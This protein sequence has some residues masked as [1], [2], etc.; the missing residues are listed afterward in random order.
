MKWSVATALGIGLLIIPTIA[1]AQP[2]VEPSLILSTHCARFHVMLGRL[3]LDPSFYK[4]VRLHQVRPEI[5]QGEEYLFVSASA[6][7]PSLHYQRTRSDH[8]VTID[9]LSIDALR[10][11][12]TRRLNSGIDE[13]LLIEQPSRGPIRV[14]HRVGSN[15]REFSSASF[16]H[17]LVESPLL[18]EQ[19]ILPLLSLM[20]QRE[21]WQ[22]GADEIQQRLQQRASSEPLVTRQQIHHWVKQLSSSQRSQRQAARKQLLSVGVGVLPI[23]ATIDPTTLDAEQKMRIGQIEKHMRCA[24]QDTPDRVAAWLATDYKYW[25]VACRDWPTH[26]RSAASQYMMLVCKRPLGSPADRIARNDSP[27][28][29]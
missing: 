15:S 20:I 11:E 7:V 4:K 12:K 13:S 23:L 28:T 16:W 1:K 19:E 25:S 5:D 8:Q 22:R 17:M 18:F 29:R 6:G 14:T 26:Q 3:H 21:P 10:I 9:T 27:S 2:S 24:R